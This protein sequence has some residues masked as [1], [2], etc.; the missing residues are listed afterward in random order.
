M[1]RRS[2]RSHWNQRKHDPSSYHRDSTNDGNQPG[3]GE[4]AEAASNPPFINPYTDEQQHRADERIYWRQ[5]IKVGDSLNKITAA[6]AV[7]AIVGLLLVGMSYC[8]ARDA[9]MRANRAWLTPNRSRYVVPPSAGG[10]AKIEIIYGNS[11]HEPAEGF[12]AQ[13]EFATVQSG[14]VGNISSYDLLDHAEFVGAQTTF[15]KICDQANPPP[16]GTLDEGP[17]Q[18]PSSPYELTYPLKVDAGSLP[19][20]ADIVSGNRTLIIHGCFAYRTFGRIHKSEY[21]MFI[22]APQGTGFAD[23]EWP[24]SS[25]CLRLNSAD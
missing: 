14:L 25:M 12:V 17:P 8:E 24:H 13:Q 4:P 19:H 11:G 21:C 9:T 2:R 23:A 15:S 20:Y 6:A 3:K 22:A 18:Y 1:G 7:I 10:P 16:E 5:Q